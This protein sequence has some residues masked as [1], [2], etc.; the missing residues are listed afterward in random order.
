MTTSYALLDICVTLQATT[1]TFARLDITPSMELVKLARS[2][3][4]AFKV[5][6]RTQLAQLPLSDEHFRQ[7]E[8]LFVESSMRESS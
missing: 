7:L 3:M 2:T 4:D 1:T 6:K 8:T 5:V